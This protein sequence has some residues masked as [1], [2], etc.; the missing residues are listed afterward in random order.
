MGAA[1]AGKM[2]AYDFVLNAFGGGLDAQKGCLGGNAP[3]DFSPS[4]QGLFHAGN[5]GVTPSEGLGMVGWTIARRF[6]APDFL[7]K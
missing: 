4:Y 5:P 6:A 7:R 2:K 1:V 3:A